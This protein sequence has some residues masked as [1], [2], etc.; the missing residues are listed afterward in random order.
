MDLF[1]SPSALSLLL[2]SP[3]KW[4]EKYVEKKEEVKDTT[5]AQILGSLVH[6]LL[7]RPLE[8]ND[9]FVV[10]DVKL[11]SG[12]VRK[13]VNSV[14]RLHKEGKL[15]DYREDILKECININLYQKLKE[16]SLRIEKI[17]KDGNNYF[18]YLKT[19]GNK[20]LVSQEQYDYAYEASEA[21]KANEAAKE[22]LGL[23]LKVHLE[24]HFEEEVR[25]I[26]PKY[27]HFGLKGILDQHLVDHE[28]REIVVNDLKCLMSKKLKDFPESVEYWRYDRQIAVYSLLLIERYKE[29]IEQGYSF[30]ANFIVIDKD[31]DIYKFPI[32]EATLIG[33]M[34]NLKRTLNN[35]EWHFVEN[36]F[37][38]PYEF[39]KNI[40]EL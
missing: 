22:A 23:Q 13:V 17:L 38:L 32:R 10:S 14:F 40:I 36:N 29:L 5:E 33:Y 25:A 3:K 37:I 21:I 30:K 19:I 20:T 34:E 9:N 7:L 27:K 11:P 39:A 12:N 24:V 15:A 16:D 2:Y 35:V 1:L 18:E 26:L 8:V 31:L 4:Y 6:C 28:K